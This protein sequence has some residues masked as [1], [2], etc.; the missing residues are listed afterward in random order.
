MTNNSNRRKTFT[1][2]AS[3]HLELCKLKLELQEIAQNKGSTKLRI[4]FDD[5]IEKLLGVYLE[6]TQNIP[7]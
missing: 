7:Q 5:V 2:N 1:I 6:Y 3:T 4:T